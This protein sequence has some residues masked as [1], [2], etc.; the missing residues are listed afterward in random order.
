AAV[1]GVVGVGAVN[2]PSSVVVSGAEA[3]V[4]R[5]VELAG[6]AGCRT[7]RLRVGQAFH[8]PLVE[9]VLEEFA[10]VLGGVVFR[11]P[12][13]PVVSNVTG[14]VAGAGELC[15]VEYWVRH[16][17]E[18]VRFADG[19]ECLI[20]RGVTEFVE[21]GP[22]AVLSGLVQ[23]RG[24]GV[25]AIPA[26]RGS[27]GEVDSFVQALARLHTR[28]VPVTWPTLRPGPRVELPTYAFH[29]QRYWLDEPP[30][31]DGEHTPE[32]DRAFWSAV[33]GED[34]DV[35][36]RTL[37]VEEDDRQAPLREVL[38]ILAD[39]RRRSRERSEL[40]ELCYDVHWRPLAE[41]ADQP[42]GTWLRIT[43][44]GPAAAEWGAALERQGLDLVSVDVSADIAD[45]AGGAGPDAL[46][47]RLRA[48]LPD[49]P[50]R[51][52]L[53]LLALAEDEDPAPPLAATHALVRALGELEVAAP[54]W[55][56]TRGAVAVTGG[57]EIRP[58][59]AQVWGLGRVAALEH[60]ERWGGLVDLPEEIG[61]RD[62]ERLAA[63]LA[64]ATG[65]DQVALRPGGLLARRL[66]RAPLAATAGG[67]GWAPRGA[68]L[69]TGGTGALGAHV[70][71][72]L[73]R[74]G[75]EHLVL[76]SRR[77]PLAPEAAALEAELTGLGARV[78]IAACDVA[79]RGALDALLDK[80]AAD[81]VRVRAVLHTAGVAQSSRID[82][83]G[84][85]DV[86]AISAGK[87]AGA[88]HLDEAFAEAELDAFVLF[89]STA[90]IWGG[91]GQ[92][93]YAAANAYL[94]ALA[95]R[96]RTRGA[97]ATSVAWGPWSEGGM[98]A[99]D[100]AEAHLRRRGVRALAP[101]TALTL[102]RQAIDQR[103]VRLT[104]ADVDW[105]RFALS[106][107]SARPSTLLS[108]IPEARRAQEPSEPDR[109]GA[110]ELSRRLSGLS[111][112]ERQQVLTDLVRRH[113]A[114]VL[115]HTGIDAVEAD[116]PFRDVGFD[117]LAA[118]EFRN[119]LT[120]A[121]GLGLSATSIFD[122]PTP[123]E[124]AEHLGSE[125]GGDELSEKALLAEID[126]LEGRLATV[127]AQ[128]A[129][130]ADALARLTALVERW[131]T[132]APGEGATERLHSA[133]R[134]EIFDFIDNELGL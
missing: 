48:A 11:E 29:R 60:P 98:A 67:T 129:P 34:M 118:V 71:R 127:A 90:G 6:A 78:T 116:K 10:A 79:D 24:E 22:E 134:D 86:A 128:A 43:A 114:A 27:Q 77:G 112:A 51:G 104:V 61:A 97:V 102:L 133:T 9:P 84:P 99:R 20:D 54:L 52:V 74:E 92:G 57:E 130:P 122:Y 108:D 1:G 117:S 19:V 68:V 14:A 56:L 96:R 91:A 26:V 80:L 88:R 42:A 41:P 47:E 126:R 103:V 31:T 53:S 101:D 121:T 62:A 33:E 15:G 70:A 32:V 30:A 8:S 58:A 87:V 46:T 21:V 13:V 7:R 89:S 59:Q 50:V 106:Y 95:E 111:G 85:D 82:E 44:G 100:D 37:G 115:G 28:G 72:W 109:D 63:V 69:V 36:A 132:P 3:A 93:A 5:V 35:L 110:D 75:A 94:D 81:G 55:C 25:V 17:R 120:E 23:G 107:T 39:W 131:S 2:G 73:A 119:R 45:L 18:A 123:R 12:V 4:G 40:G 113:A 49:T 125:L 64:G 124:L 16:A 76:T 65:E 66:R 83:T 38:P 105:E